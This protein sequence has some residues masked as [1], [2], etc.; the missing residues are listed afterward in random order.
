VIVVLHQVSKFVQLEQAAFDKM[1][2]MSA[3]Y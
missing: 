1:I 3:L 2:T